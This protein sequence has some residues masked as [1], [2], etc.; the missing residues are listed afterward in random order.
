MNRTY[1]L[2]TE[3]RRTLVEY[4]NINAVPDM[5]IAIGTVTVGAL[6]ADAVSVRLLDANGAS[7][8]ELAVAT[9]LPC[10]VAIGSLIFEADVAPGGDVRFLQD[11]TPIGDN[12][13][14]ETDDTYIGSLWIC[15]TGAGVVISLGSSEDAGC[16]WV[17]DSE[18]ETMAFA[19]CSY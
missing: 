5:D 14:L 19:D 16:E 3:N 6:L 13:F 15:S 8:R 12:I 18:L 2:V 11:G 10:R 4:D 1:S 7:A 17:A 9:A